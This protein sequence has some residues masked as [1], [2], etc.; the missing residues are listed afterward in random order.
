M[1]HPRFTLHSCPQATTVRR[2]LTI[3][4][5]VQGVGFRQACAEAARR[6][7]VTGWVRNRRSGAV[8][9]VFEGPPA[10]VAAMV[11]WCRSGPRM[12]E[13]ISVELREEDPEGL[14]TFHLATTA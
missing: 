2:R 1:D 5:R 10:A 12:A 13:V 6:Q 8:E 3:S 7:G 14:T 4:G 9:A 11:D